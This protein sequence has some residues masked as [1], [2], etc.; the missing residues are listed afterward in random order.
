MKNK[1]LRSL[2]MARIANTQQ[3]YGANS[4]KIPTRQEKCEGQ[5][6]RYQ[7][8]KIKSVDDVLDMSNSYWNPS[9]IRIVLKK[10]YLD[11]Y[12]YFIPP[13][14]ILTSGKWVFDCTTKDDDS[15]EEGDD[16]E[17][18]P[19]CSYT[20]DSLMVSA[21]QN[22]DNPDPN[23]ILFFNNYKERDDDEYDNPSYNYT[24]SNYDIFLRL[25]IPYDDSPDGVY[26]KANT[27][28][29]NYKKKEKTKNQ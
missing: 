6:N 8:I 27:L 2:T 12:M 3:A 25:E 9:E 23:L 7:Y 14:I 19:C 11:V 5:V 22:Y 21:V 24:G 10:T 16:K 28:K 1:K 29:K 13:G 18:D 17:D 20:I 26:I 15:G 4:T